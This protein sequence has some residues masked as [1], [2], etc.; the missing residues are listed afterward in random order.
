ML[1]S[2]QELS[3]FNDIPLRENISGHN[4]CRSWVWGGEKVLVSFND[5]PLRENIS[6]HNV[7]LGFAE[8]RKCMFLFKNS[9]I[10][11]TSLFVK[12]LRA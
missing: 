2:F 10:L 1:V 3:P 9:S 7:V 8:E 11:L 12:Y 5:I 4:V 6:G